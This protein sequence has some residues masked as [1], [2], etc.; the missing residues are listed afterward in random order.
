ME[1]EAK[2]LAKERER[3]RERDHIY[4]H[5]QYDGGAKILGGEALHNHPTTRVVIAHQLVQ[6]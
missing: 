4:W 5:D 2:L 1:A 3:E 6:R